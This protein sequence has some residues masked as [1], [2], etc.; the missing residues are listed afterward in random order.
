MT[1]AKTLEKTIT[2]N[3]DGQQVLLRPAR[4]VDERQVQ[5]HFYNLDH[6]DVVRRFMHEKTAFLRKDVAEVYQIDYIR[7]MTIVAVIGEPIERNL[8]RSSRQFNRPVRGS[9]LLTPDSVRPT[10]NWRGPSA[11]PNRQGVA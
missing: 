2:I 5:E 4:P 10:I 1:I 8:N 7:D 9:R 3:I 6:Q 11:A